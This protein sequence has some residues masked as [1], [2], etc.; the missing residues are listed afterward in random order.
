M[1]R[2]G[3]K[4]GYTLGLRRSGEFLVERGERQAL[5]DRQRQIGRVISGQAVFER[6]SRATR[7]SSPP[8]SR[9]SRIIF[10]L[11]DLKEQGVFR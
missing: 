1:T 6:E 10:S 3:S 9:A 5:D 11:A 8:P 7:R 4:D 2:P